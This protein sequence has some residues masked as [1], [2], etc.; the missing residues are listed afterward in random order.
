MYG[1]LWAE[2]RVAGRKDTVI[3]SVACLNA[4]GLQNCR[5]A[6]MSWHACKPVVQA[7]VQVFTSV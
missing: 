6:A 2:F 3:H 7:T 1:Q 4:S 5:P